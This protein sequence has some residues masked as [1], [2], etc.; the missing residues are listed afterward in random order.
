MSSNLRIVGAIDEAQI[1]RLQAGQQVDIRVDAHPDCVFQGVIDR[2]SPLGNGKETSSVVTG[3]GV[4][5]TSRLFGSK[6]GPSSATVEILHLLE[7]QAIRSIVI[8]K[9]RTDANALGQLVGPPGLRARRFEP[10]PP[11]AS[12]SSPTTAGTPSPAALFACSTATPRRSSACS[13]RRRRGAE[14]TVA[15]SFAPWRNGLARWDVAESSS[16]RQPPSKRRRACT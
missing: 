4:M 11:E 13:S 2:V 9:V 1:G 3:S 16:T 6:L 14:A 10:T 15:R 8:A 7:V 5:V 12:F